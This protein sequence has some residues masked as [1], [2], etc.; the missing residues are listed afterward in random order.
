MS[1]RDCAMVVWNALVIFGSSIYF[2]LGIWR[3]ALLSIAVLFSCMIGYGRRWFLR[4][5]F[6]TFVVT[7][8][9]VAGVLPQPEDWRNVITQA[10]EFVTA[11]AR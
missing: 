4:A 9:I 1:D 10:K 7:L 2:G 6:L 5:G 3:A 11:L 8:L